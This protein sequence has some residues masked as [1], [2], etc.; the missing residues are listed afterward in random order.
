MWNEENENEE[1]SPF[2]SLHGP[3]EKEEQMSMPEPVS[4]SD[5]PNPWGDVSPIDMEPSTM[6]ESTMSTDEDSEESVILPRNWKKDQP[7]D[8]GT[9][10]Y[11]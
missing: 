10:T 7:R 6:E 9:T 3:S 4:L 1:D 5:L 8:V 2:W 11:T